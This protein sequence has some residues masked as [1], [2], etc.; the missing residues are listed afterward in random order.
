MCNLATKIE[1]L[2]AK[3]RQVHSPTADEVQ[4]VA[5]AEIEEFSRLHE[6]RQLFT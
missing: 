6:D 1:H 2:Q 3:A 5:E 4:I